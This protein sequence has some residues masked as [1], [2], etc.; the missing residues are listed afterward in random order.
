MLF[1]TSIYHACIRMTLCSYLR[2]SN[3]LVIINSRPHRF[4]KVLSVICSS[5]I[6]AMMGIGTTFL[7]AALSFFS[8]V[9]AGK[10]LNTTCNIFLFMTSVNI[11]IDL[12]VLTVDFD[13]RNRKLGQRSLKCTIFNKFNVKI[14][15]L[16]R[17]QTKKTYTEHC[18]IHKTCLSL[19]FSEKRFISKYFLVKNQYM[20][21]AKI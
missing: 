16:S 2:P 20:K 17:R 19:L 6:A 15:F 11:A 7:I 8:F 1:R 18:N 12:T 9:S 10:N 4:L 5:K 14:Y 3:K 13:D 21:I